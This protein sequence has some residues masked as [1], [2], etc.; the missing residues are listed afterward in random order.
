MLP[1]VT[2]ILGPFTDFS[3]IPPDVLAHAA[4]RGTIVHEACAAI[5]SGLW[6]PALP[7]ECNGYVESFRRW[8]RLVAKVHLVEEE[9]IHPTY[10][11]IGHLDLCVTMQGDTVPRIVDLKT[12]L[13]ESPTWSAQ[14]AAYSELVRV[15][16]G[17][18]TRR[19]GS[20]RLDPKGGLPK[21]TEYRESSRD[22]SAFLNALGAWNYFKGGK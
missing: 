2:Q 1:S 3:R 16:G 10:N 12:P 22:L 7:E 5:S 21:F 4:E 14:I 17:I 20:L 13:S 8:F 18:V 9:L 15:A 11:Y 19:N 6:V